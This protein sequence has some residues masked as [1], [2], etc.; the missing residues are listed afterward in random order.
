VCII[1]I[2]TLLKWY[3]SLI[4]V[5]FTFQLW[6]VIYITCMSDK[7]HRRINNH[8]LPLCNLIVQR[9]PTQTNHTQYV[10]HWLT[11][12]RVLSFY[13]SLCVCVFFFVYVNDCNVPVGGMKNNDEYKLMTK[14]I[15]I[16]ILTLLNYYS[17]SK[18]LAHY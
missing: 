18:F 5:I 17:F 6:L 2:Y 12:Y 14:I 9:S 3:L 1:Y 10:R 13:S 4:L 16:I 7:S 11:V 15:I 8:I